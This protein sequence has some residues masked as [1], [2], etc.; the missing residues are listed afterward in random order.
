MHQIRIRYPRP[1]RLALR[2][3]PRHKYSKLPLLGRYR[4]SFAV[5]ASTPYTVRSW[6][7]LYLPEQHTSGQGSG[8]TS[9]R[10]DESSTNNFLSATFLT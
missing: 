9:L 4:P 1:V 8:I 3:D 10:T 5:R 6:Y 7:H 2:Q